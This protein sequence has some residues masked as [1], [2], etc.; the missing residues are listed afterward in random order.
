[1]DIQVIDKKKLIFRVKNIDYRFVKP[2]LLY[3]D[4]G[5]FIKGRVKGSTLGWSLNNE[6]LSYNK[7]KNMA[8]FG[9][10]WLDE[11]LDNDKPMFGSNWLDE[12]HFEYFIN[13]EGEYQ[14]IETKRELHDAIDNNNRF[15]FDGKNYNLKPQQ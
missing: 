1:M 12:T 11:K 10:S 13:D 7:L 14:K 15:T 2:N 6:F 3:F 5:N 9:S 4:F 8:L